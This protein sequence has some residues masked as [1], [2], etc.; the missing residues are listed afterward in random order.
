MWQSTDTGNGMDKKLAALDDAVGT[1]QVPHVASQRC[2]PLFDIALENS[3]DRREFYRGVIV[4]HAEKLTIGACRA[5][6]LRPNPCDLPLV[7]KLLA[8]LKELYGLKWLLF[9]SELWASK[10]DSPL[11]EWN[12]DWQAEARD[13][14]AWHRKRGRLVGIPDYL[15]DEEYHKR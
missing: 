9:M 6:M 10:Q 7:I 1:G 14:P 11:V 3:T 4:G 2:R 5:F 15:I 12:A 8:E 13:S